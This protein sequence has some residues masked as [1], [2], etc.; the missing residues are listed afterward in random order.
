MRTFLFILL[1]FLV[2]TANSQILSEDF[3]SGSLPTSWGQ[4]DNNEL[5][6]MTDWYWEFNSGEMQHIYYYSSAYPADADAWTFTPNIA[7]TSGNTYRIEFDL[8]TT[9]D[10]LGL[11]GPAAMKLTVGLGK[12]SGA[13][14]TVLWTD[15]NITNS[16]YVTKS[17]DFV[18]PTDGDYNFGFHCFSTIGGSLNTAAN[19]YIDNVEIT[20]LVNSCVDESNVY[21]FTFGG[22]DYE[23]VKEQKTWAEAAAC[24]VERDGYLVEI[25]SLEEQNAVYVA[26]ADA[27]VS[28]NYAV[29]DCGGGIAYVWTGG[30]DNNIEGTWLWDGD[31]DASGTNFYTGQG[32]AG[33]GDGLIIDNSYVNWGTTG[34]SEPDNFSYAGVCNNDQDAVGIALAGWPHGNAGEWN[35]IQDD[36]LLYFIVEKTSDVGVSS[37]KHEIKFYP[38]PT[39]GKFVVNAENIESVEILDITG[40]LVKQLTTNNEQLIID[41][42]HNPKGIYFVRMTIESQVSCKKLILEY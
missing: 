13:Q 6:W 20:E 11:Y 5:N 22:K 37:P 15:A 42:S 26:I 36:E 16:T 12:S 29:V 14:T 31:N 33:A 18:C 32:T 24:A 41:L 1:W 19:T 23:V 27:G 10:D 2:S 3:S 34:G 39:T 35:D 8:N 21:S 38:N 28:T 9:A 25:N 17:F 40:R 4:E 30:A 7:M